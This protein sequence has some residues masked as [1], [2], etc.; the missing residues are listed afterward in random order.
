MRPRKGEILQI[1]GMV[2]GDFDA[3]EPEGWEPVS[4]GRARDPEGGPA[5]TMR[6]VSD[7]LRTFH[8]RWSSEVKKSVATCSGREEAFPTISMLLREEGAGC[9]R[10]RRELQGRGAT[11]NRRGQGGRRGL[12]RGKRSSGA[13]GG[14]EKPI[15]PLYFAVSGYIS[16]PDAVASP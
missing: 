4:A 15:I 12:L 6:D 1:S 11:G 13:R 2:K 10:D 14:S 8:D 16:P 3:L 5:R 7:R 9:E